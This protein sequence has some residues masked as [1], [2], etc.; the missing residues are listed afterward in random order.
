MKT[1]LMREMVGETLR[2]LRV[3]PSLTFREVSAGRG[4]ASATFPRLSGGRRRRR[5]R[6]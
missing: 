3:R 4:S 6:C 2:D 5:Q 1:L